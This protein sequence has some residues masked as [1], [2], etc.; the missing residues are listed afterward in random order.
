[1]IRLRNRLREHLT[2]HYVTIRDIAH[3]ADV[4]HDAV[5]RVIKT[6]GDLP[7]PQATAIARVLGVPVEELF[8]VEREA[9]PGTRERLA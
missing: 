8:W 7:V 3:L 2:D 5:S 4:S 1:M 6:Q 9:T